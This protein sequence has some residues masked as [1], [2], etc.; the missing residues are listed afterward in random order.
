MRNEKRGGAVYAG[1][2]AQQMEAGWKPDG[3]LM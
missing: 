2:A 1:G 3:K